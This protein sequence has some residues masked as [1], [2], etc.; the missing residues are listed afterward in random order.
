MFTH[1]TVKVSACSGV[2]R[3]TVEAEL[4]W[5]QFT[6]LN[7]YM[8]TQYTVKTCIS[9]CISQNLPFH[10]LVFSIYNSVRTV[11]S[12]C[13]CSGVGEV[14]SVCE[15]E[16]GFWRGYRWPE[17]SKLQQGQMQAIRDGE[18]TQI[19][20]QNDKLYILQQFNTTFSQL[21]HMHTQF[22]SS[23]LSGFILRT[24]RTNP[25]AFLT[26][27]LWLTSQRVFVCEH[28]CVGGVFYNWPVPD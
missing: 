13:F 8:K 19:R 21:F 20:M 27:A 18:S 24:C 9:S 1:N 12:V 7:M 14:Q 16:T 25:G 3:D 5:T 28:M 4:V 15:E 17:C 11:F 26:V 22:Y 10:W 6:C 23:V 2:S